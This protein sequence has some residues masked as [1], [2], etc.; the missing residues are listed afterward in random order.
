[1]IG[2]SEQRE[3]P[4]SSIRGDAAALTLQCRLLQKRRLHKGDFA[5][6][7][8]LQRIR[9]KRVKRIEKEGGAPNAR[10]CPTKDNIQ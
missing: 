3:R 9:N 4:A 10:L 8:F 2:G 5:K 1:M 7:R 6:G